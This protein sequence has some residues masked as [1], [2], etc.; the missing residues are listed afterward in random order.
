MSTKMDTIRE[1][2]QN[3]LA[4]AEARRAASKDAKGGVSALSKNLLTLHDEDKLVRELLA[5][6]DSHEADGQLVLTLN[7]QKL[8]DKLHG[9]DDVYAPMFAGKASHNWSVFGRNVLATLR[10]DVA[11]AM[12]RTASKALGVECPIPDGKIDKELAAAC[13]EVWS[14]LEGFAVKLGKIPQSSTTSY[15]VREDSPALQRLLSLLS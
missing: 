15:V 14:E 9:A 11:P 7:P 5:S 13:L 8:F 6:T 4:N 12:I 2:I 3:I 10:N 1:K